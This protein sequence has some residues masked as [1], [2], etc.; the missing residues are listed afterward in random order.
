MSLARALAMPFQLTSL[1]LVGFISIAAALCMAFVHAVGA[2]V[3]LPL[4]FLLS[5]LNKYACALLDHAANGVVAAP[6]ASTEM[7]GP[8]GGVR[9]LVHVALGTAIAALLRFG[10]EPWGTYLGL[11]VMLLFPASVGA[12][13]L[14]QRSFDAVYPPALWRVLRG[15]GFYYLP[16]LAALAVC[17]GGIYRLAI[18]PLWPALSYLLM[19]LLWLCLH[20]LIGGTLFLR[21]AA[22]DFVP[23]QSPEWLA[24][25][26]A[27][28]HERQRQGV[29]DAVYTSIRVSD[30]PRASAAL[31][32]WLA[33]TEPGQRRADA[34]A[35]VT[36]AAR[37]PEQRGLRTVA[38]TLVAQFMK[39]RQLSTALS[40]AEAALAQA[41]DFELDSAADTAAL[42]QYAQSCGR[43]RVAQQL[44]ENFTRAGTPTS[45]GGSARS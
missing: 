41:G 39:S 13:A 40:T 33:A 14:Q 20:T 30:V 21:R 38:R 37:W 45:R 17:A 27:H 26:D 44:H 24:E 16:L 36:Q 32:A 7:L 42:A 19:A 2:L 12:A 3:I 22:L 6:V 31:L 10:P 4:L 28:E 29:I 5:W 9:P 43:T 8:F 25:R 35:I 1:L 23:T 11:A 34:L 18:S 15:L